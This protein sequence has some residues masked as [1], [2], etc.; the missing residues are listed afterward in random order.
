MDVCFPIIESKLM[1]RLLMS[2]LTNL[3]KTR[4]CSVMLCPWESEV[5]ERVYQ[6]TLIWEKLFMFRW[7]TVW[8]MYSFCIFRWFQ[9]CLTYHDISG[10]HWWL[11]SYS[12]QALEGYKLKAEF[13]FSICLELF[14]SLYCNFWH[15]FRRLHDDAW[16]TYDQNRNERR[17]KE[18]NND[19]PVIANS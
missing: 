8:E 18:N 5:K 1:Q 6:V 16:R 11:C 15:I 3:L 10:P 14:F 7:K 9:S 12:S 2:L 17:A 4:W 19:I 13:L